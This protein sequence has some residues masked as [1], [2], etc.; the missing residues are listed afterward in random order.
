MHQSM[1]MV[2]VE[3]HL[4]GEI[5]WNGCTANLNW[6]SYGFL[7]FV[8]PLGLQL[9]WHCSRN[10]NRA[11][12]HSAPTGK[13]VCFGP[14]GS[15]WSIHFFLPCPD[16]AKRELSRVHLGYSFPIFFGPQISLCLI[17]SG[18]MLWLGILW[19]CKSEPSLGSCIEFNLYSFTCPPS[20]ECKTEG[21]TRY[22][23]NCNHSGFISPD[24]CSY[25]IWP[26]FVAFGQI[27]NLCQSTMMVSIS[28][29]AISE[30]L[31]GEKRPK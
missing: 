20:A 7:T 14:W 28:F 15:N 13:K 19:S 17:V 1:T 11:S 9:H 27:E 6:A 18:W 29:F 16:G 8:R 5:A 23:R 31:I 10:F 24:Y 25:E 4:K 30:A 21:V 12:A 26:L 22:G 2:T 3:G